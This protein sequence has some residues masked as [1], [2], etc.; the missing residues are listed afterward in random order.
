M[1]DASNLDVDLYG[2]IVTARQ[3]GQQVS[4]SANPMG[5]AM[6]VRREGPKLHTASTAGRGDDGVSIAESA[7][8]FIVIPPDGLLSNMIG[9]PA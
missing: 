2:G 8:V 7:A 3:S 5:T 1:D 4:R 9:A 6:A